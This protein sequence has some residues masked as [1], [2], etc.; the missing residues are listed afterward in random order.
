MICKI[1]VLRGLVFIHIFT[2][3]S[4]KGEKTKSNSKAHGKASQ[5][6]FR[7]SFPLQIGGR[8]GQ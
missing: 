6:A 7:A 4:Q 1:I 2:L 5:Y 8:R 3:L